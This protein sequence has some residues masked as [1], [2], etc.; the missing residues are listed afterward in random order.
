MDGRPDGN[1]FSF[2]N[3]QKVLSSVHINWRQVNIFVVASLQSKG[4]V[5]KMVSTAI[6]IIFLQCKSYFSLAAGKLHSNW[7][8]Q[9]WTKKL[10]CKK[11]NENTTIN[12]FV[13]SKHQLMACKL[14]VLTNAQSKGNSFTNLEHCNIFYNLQK[15]LIK[16]PIDGL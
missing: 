13:A 8:M 2:Y 16:T 6:I 9:L 10:H 15:V 12:H 14:F 4:D 7:K 5:S 11:T 1:I 3:L